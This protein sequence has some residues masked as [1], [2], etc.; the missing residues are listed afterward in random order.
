MT[1]LVVMADG[2]AVRRYRWFWIRAVTGFDPRFHCARC[3]RGRW[4]HRTSTPWPADGRLVFAFRPGEVAYV[5]GVT[6]RWSDNLHV[7]I[8]PWTPGEGAEAPMLGGGV[9]CI[10]GGIRL[11]IPA[12]PDGWRGLGREFTKCR[13]FQFG[14]AWSGLSKNEARGSTC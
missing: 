7:A 3:L 4:L 14:V 8:D 10:E 13:N 2:P 5:C 6:R 12:L 1:K 9:L 11:E